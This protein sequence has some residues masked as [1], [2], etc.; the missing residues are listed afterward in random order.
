MNARSDIDEL[1]MP[2]PEW[3]TQAFAVPRE[4][5][6]VDVGGC[7]IRFYAWGDPALPPVLMM[8]GF[9]AHARVFAFVAPLL[10][11]KFR[12]VAF[13]LSGMGDSGH[14]S[15]YGPRIDEVLAVAAHTGL[16][17][18]GSRPFIVTHSFGGT[19]G[20]DAFEQHGDRFG[21]LVICDLFMKSRARLDEQ[22]ENDD[23]ARLSA[24]AKGHKVY[25]DLQTALSRYRLS[26]AQPCANDFLL[27]FMGR[28]SLK[29]VDG[30]WI[31][32]FDAKILRE[33]RHDIEWWANLMPRFAALSA[34][35][36]IIYGR[37]STI[38]DEV[39]VADMRGLVG[40]GVPMVGIAHA[41][42]HLMLD[43]PL[44]FITALEAVLSMWLAAESAA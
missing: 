15:A 26:P 33:D 20:L 5:G 35:K 23:I 44:A 16:F 19:V 9:L 14:R 38:F 24:R 6:E 21:G 2:L 30:G 22:L 13:D 42:H 31:W 8:H 39:D 41:H 32:K 12:L 17:A 34:R 36:A 27:A 43:Q 25:P 10:A 4:T 1:P 40:P 18:H 7:P 29:R 37:Q 28:H 11:Q 3:F